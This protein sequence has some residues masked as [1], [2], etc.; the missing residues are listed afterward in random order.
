MEAEAATAWMEVVE[1]EGPSL[2]MATPTSPSS[3]RSSSLLDALPFPIGWQLLCDC[4]PTPDVLRLAGASRECAAHA[5]PCVRRLALRGPSTTNTST[6]SSSG[7][8][9]MP[10]LAG[11]VAACPRVEEVQGV[12][13]GPLGAAHLARAWGAQRASLAR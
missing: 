8:G 11:L 12:G 1:T 2:G 9:A 5:R 10:G 7:S 3:S 4:L 13:L 6:S